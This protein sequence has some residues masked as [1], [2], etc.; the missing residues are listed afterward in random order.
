MSRIRALDNFWCRKVAFL[1][2]GFD[3]ALKAPEEGFGADE[4]GFKFH[5]TGELVDC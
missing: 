3:G 1:V 4:E 2:D 5:C